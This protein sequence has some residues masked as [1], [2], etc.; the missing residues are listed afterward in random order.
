MSKSNVPVVFIGIPHSN[1][2]LKDVFTSFMTKKLPYLV[3]EPISLFQEIN[4]PQWNFINAYFIEVQAKDP[5]FNVLVS[6]FGGNDLG[7]LD[8]IMFGYNTRSY[9]DDMF[10]FLLTYNSAS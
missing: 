4:I 5:A 6:E 1:P 3:V 10:Q 9:Y 8:A 2:H 7:N